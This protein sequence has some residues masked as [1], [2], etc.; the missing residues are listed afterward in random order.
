[1]TRTKHL[2]PYLA[3]GAAALVLSVVVAVSAA[4]AD[5]ATKANPGVKKQ[6]K[7]LK[8]RLSQ[9]Q[10]R[11]EEI[12]KQ[13]GPEGAQGPEGPPGPATG[14]AGGD[15]TGTFPNPLIGP[16][17]IAS[18]EIANGTVTNADLGD[19][20]VNGSQIVDGGISV[21]DLGSG[22][23]HADA[24]RPDSVGADAL[25]ALSTVTSAGVVVNAGSPQ[26]V[27]VTCPS[28]R[29]VIGG[30]YAWLEDEANS[31]IVNAPSDAIPGRGWDVRGM[32]ATGSNTLYA[33][34]NCLAA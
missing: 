13:R 31:I 14:P 6:V 3:L 12:S 19:E 27:S 4:G 15:L 7:Q 11:V 22:S 33:W 30:G 29:A 26:S 5:P 23:V 17:A 1:M 24:M 10:Q 34:A 2:R 9:L 20:S 8:Q 28:G 25:K 21:L 16:D 18:A 32:V